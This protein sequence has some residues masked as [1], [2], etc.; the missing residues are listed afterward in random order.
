MY[1]ITPMM[2]KFKKYF[3]KTQ[4]LKNRNDPPDI[5]SPNYG[6]IY[7]FFARARNANAKEKINDEP[8]SL[9]SQA[10]V[11]SQGSNISF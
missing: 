8:P 11:V 5:F 7:Y 3:V 2:Q 4:V 10:T 6:S 1:V 9:T